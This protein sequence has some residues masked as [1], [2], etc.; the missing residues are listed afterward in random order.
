MRRVL[1]LALLAL[2]LPMTAMASSIDYTGIMPGTLTGSFATSL[3]V[4]MTLGCINGVCNSPSTPIS[5]A[6][7][8]STGSLSKITC[9]IGFSGSCYSFS[10]GSLSVSGSAVFSDTFTGGFV[11]KNGTTLSIVASLTPNSVV[12]SGSGTVSLQFTTTRTGFNVLAGSADVSYT[13]VPEPGTLGMLGTGLV[14]LA[15]LVRRKLN[16]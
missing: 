5:G 8:I 3:N 10:G 14:G 15:G 13:T 2:A 1:L 7:S 11:N 6:L 9:P 16:S 12:Q 4:N